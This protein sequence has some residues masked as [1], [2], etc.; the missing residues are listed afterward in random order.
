MTRDISDCSVDHV[1][2]GCGG[3]VTQAQG[4]RVLQQHGLA[5]GLALGGEHGP[6]AGVLGQVDA[7]AREHRVH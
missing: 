2:R 5:A 1:T 7:G 4:D 6:V 3:Q